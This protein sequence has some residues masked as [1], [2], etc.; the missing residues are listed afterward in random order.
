MEDHAGQFQIVQFLFKAIAQRCQIVCRLCILRQVGS[1]CT[2]HQLC[3]LGGADLCQLFLTCQYV[4][5]QLFKI[6]LVDFIH[7]IQHCHIL[8]QDDHLVFQTLYNL[9]DVGFCLG[10]LCL[11]GVELVGVFS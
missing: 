9:V 10:I 3:Q 1:S 6:G 8:E 2:F 5:R 4:H 7:F 11:H